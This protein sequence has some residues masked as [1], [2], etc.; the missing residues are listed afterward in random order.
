MHEI[1]RATARHGIGFALV[2]LSLTFAL[3]VSLAFAQRAAAAG[4]S[5]LAEGLHIST[6]AIVDPDDR[7]WVADHNAGFCRI[8][9][10]TDGPGVHRPPAASRRGRRP[11]LPRRS[12]P[13]G[14]HRPRRRGPARLHRPVAR[15]REQRRRVRAHPGRRVAELRRGPRGLEPRHGALR[16]P[17]H[18]HDGRR[19]RRG[20]PA[21]GRG[22]RRARR[23]RL[24]RL[25]A[26]GHDPADRRPRVADARR[27]TSSP[28]PRT[29][30]AR[31]PSPRRTARAARVAAA[32]RRRRDDRPARGRRHRDRLRPRRGRPSTR[33]STFRARSS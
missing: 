26:L 25:P 15:V 11:H 20:P 33:A 18:H 12:P 30:A 4:P 14:G 8:K 16:V 28:P 29:A 17:R 10:S 1:V 3:S 19:R 9:P 2:A 13:G 22:E 6:G 21:P 7:V 5:L 31:A 23:Q 27:S 32:H 24:R